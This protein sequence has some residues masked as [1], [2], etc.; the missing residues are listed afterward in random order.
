MGSRLA[1]YFSGPPAADGRFTVANRGDL[2]TVPC[3]LTEAPPAVLCRRGL[4][5]SARALDA[6]R[7]AWGADLWLHRVE[8]DGEVVEGV[9]KVAG[10]IRRHLWAAPADATLRAFA[11]RCALDVGHL[12]DMPEVVRR[13]LETGNE[14]LRSAAEAAAWAAAEDAAEDAAVAAAWDAAGSAA[15]AAAGAAAEDAAVDAAVAAAWN[16]A[17]AAAVAAAR[18]AQAERLDAMML[19]LAPVEVPRG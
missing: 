18:D 6:L 12:W 16:A 19:A 11:R 13:Y 4:H 15:G 10:T 1:W 14:S 3:T 5:A 7:Y 2:Y 9:D 17:R 8:V